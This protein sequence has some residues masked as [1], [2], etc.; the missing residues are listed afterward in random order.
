MALALVRVVLYW[1]SKA[2][3]D[4]EPKTPVRGEG[5]KMDAVKYVYWRDED[6]WIGYL[7]EYPDYWTQGRTI[8]ELEENLMDVYRELSGGSISHLQKAS[9]RQAK[10]GRLRIESLPV[11]RWSLKRLLKRITEEN[12]HGEVNTGGA[13]GNEVW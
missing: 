9:G 8:E 7:E 13:V 11:R 2:A 12:T 10:S 1:R 4:D 5:R 3:S 6:M